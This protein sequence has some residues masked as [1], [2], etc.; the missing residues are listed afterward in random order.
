MLRCLLTCESDMAVA[1]AVTTW[2]GCAKQCAVQDVGSAVEL[3]CVSIQCFKDFQKCY[4][5]VCRVCCLLLLR[6]IPAL[7]ALA[8]TVG[9][10]RAKQ[11]TDPHIMH[12]CLGIC[13]CHVNTDVAAAEDMQYPVRYYCLLNRS[14]CSTAAKQDYQVCTASARGRCDL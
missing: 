7:P 4:G 11:P 5:A 1:T 13:C 12:P 3:K 9:S 10:C 8:C 6:S 2:A 14:T